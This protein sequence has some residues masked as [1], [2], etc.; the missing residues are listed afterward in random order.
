VSGSTSGHEKPR[1]RRIVLLRHGRTSWNAEGRFQ[2]QTD[3]PL[4]DVGVDQARRVGALLAGLRPDRIVSSDLSRA[5][6]TAAPLAAITRLD[7]AVDVR[8][9]ET[10][11]GRWQGLTRAEI[12]AVEPGEFADWVSGRGERPGGGE[13][14]TEVAD[15]ATEC[16]E[17]LLAP[18]E[19]G[20]LL[21]VVTHGGT[22][23]TLVGSLLGLAEPQWPVLGGLAN[24][25][26]SFLDEPA[27]R[28]GGRVGG[29]RLVEHNA[30]SLPEPVLGD[31][32]P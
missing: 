2:G 7:V 25:C 23:R 32:T 24:A 10:H 8:L 16:L 18:L 13:S 19:P 17:E 20:Q 1:G 12:E 26:W 14:R 29:W 5:R 15:R 4:D 21:V 22:A 31:E 28:A 30:G 3:V 11:G 27:F 9:R 6:N